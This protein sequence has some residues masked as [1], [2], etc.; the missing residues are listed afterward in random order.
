[1]S[2]VHNQ[3]RPNDLTRCLRHQVWL[4][5]CDTCREAHAHLL[6]GRREDRAA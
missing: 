4:A 5:A 2:T 6:A 3:N 1:V